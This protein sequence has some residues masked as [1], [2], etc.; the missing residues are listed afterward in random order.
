MDLR[1]LDLATLYARCIGTVFLG[2]AA[3]MLVHPQGNLGADSIQFDEMPVAGRAEVRA[4]YVGTALTLG[5]AMTTL[6]AGTAVWLIRLV[7]GGLAL[8]R[9]VA[10]A[11][12]G[13]DSKQGKGLQLIG[14][15]SRICNSYKFPIYLIVIVQVW[16]LIIG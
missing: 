11:I 2:I 13:V 9:V 4:Y 15:L 14:G 1:T 3:F 8:T 5:S 10:Y 6:E 16:H 12:D 7:L